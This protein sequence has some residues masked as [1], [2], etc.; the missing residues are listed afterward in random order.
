M[1]Y[2]DSIPQELLEIIYEHTDIVSSIHLSE[3][4]LQTRSIYNDEWVWYRILQNNYSKLYHL[5]DSGDKN[6]DSARNLYYFYRDNMWEFNTSINSPPNLAK[7]YCYGFCWDKYKFITHVLVK[8]DWPGIYDRLLLLVKED[9]KHRDTNGDRSWGRIIDSLLYTLRFESVEIKEYF[10]T[11]IPKDN[12]SSLDKLYN[13]IPKNK[14]DL[15]MSNNYI[16]IWLYCND[17]NVDIN[18]SGQIDE[19]FYFLYRIAKSLHKSIKNIVYKLNP[20]NV[21]II[22]YSLE[23]II[24]LIYY[25]DDEVSCEHRRQSILKELE[26]KY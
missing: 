26:N 8:S 9:N 5:L 19:L 25:S 14:S 16:L 12:I 21:G 3:V 6:A 23:G 4:S 13:S 11:G 20:E 1:S 10:R 17:D 15:F 24:K 7:N 2:F 18:D 22:Y